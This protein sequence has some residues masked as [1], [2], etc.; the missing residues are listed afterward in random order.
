MCF[1]SNGHKGTL[2]YYRA[3][4]ERGNFEFVT[5]KHHYES[6]PPKRCEEI[7]SRTLLQ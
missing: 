3:M 1:F 4:E 7:A 2:P 6:D 5:A